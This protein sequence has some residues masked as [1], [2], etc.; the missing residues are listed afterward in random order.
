M[1][2]LSYIRDMPHDKTVTFRA[3]KRKV[4]QIDKIAK[5]HSRS[6]SSLLQTLIDTMLKIDEN[7][8]LEDLLL[9][10]AKSLNSEKS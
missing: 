8:Q 9:R 2:R 7:G 5:R 6:R 4:R 10:T 1:S 3:N